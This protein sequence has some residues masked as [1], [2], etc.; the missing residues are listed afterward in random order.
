LQGTPDPVNEN[1]KA[2]MT[3]TGPIMPCPVQSPSPIKVCK[4]VMKVNDNAFTLEPEPGGPCEDAFRDLGE[5]VPPGS[6]RYFIKKVV[7]DDEKLRAILDKAK[8]EA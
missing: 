5:K 1:T 4:V 7:T 2:A 6:R 8:K 3:L